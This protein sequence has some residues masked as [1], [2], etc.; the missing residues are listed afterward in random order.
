MEAP[1]IP[2]WNSMGIIPPVDESD[3]TSL[4]RSP[5]ELDIVRFVS[6]FAITQSRVKILKGFLDFRNE[7]TS[8]GLVD[9]FQW[10]D[11]SFT[12][13]VE[14]IERRAPNDVDV[15]TFFNF[16]PGD[17]D[18][19]VYSRNPNIF[20]QDFVKKQYLVDSYFE[21][22]HAPGASLVARTVYWYSMW[23]HKRDL[24]W[25]GFIQIPLSPALDLVARSILDSIETEEANNESK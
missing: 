16:Q 3:P 6:L 8:V 19:T 1:T 9:G 24:S 17:N 7:L 22:L 23:A 21:G 5:Y 20:N 18:H 15:V 11:G 14:L 25:K 10:V 13:N 12:E 2:L 4:S